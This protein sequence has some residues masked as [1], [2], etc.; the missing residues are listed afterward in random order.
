[1]DL[2]QKNVLI[3]ALASTSFNRT[4]TKEEK[5]EQKKRLKSHFAMP[6]F[7]KGIESPPLK[8]APEGLHCMLSA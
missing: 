8:I 7:C 1:M 4:A 6:N 2:V 5:A 3:L